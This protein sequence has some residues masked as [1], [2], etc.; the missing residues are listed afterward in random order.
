MTTFSQTYAY[1][2]QYLSLR[3]LSRVFSKLKSNKSSLLKGRITCSSQ[4]IVDLINER[5][6]N[7][8][9]SS[10]DRS[11]DEML[12]KKDVSVEQAKDMKYK[13]SIDFLNRLVT[14]V[15]VNQYKKKLDQFGK[16]FDIYMQRQ[17]SFIKI[18][19]NTPISPIF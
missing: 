16:E 4:S 11:N 5:C 3:Q 14:K 13:K 19:S 2:T 7:R 18:Y 6:A 10:P 17:G 1:E 12:G 15:F 9:H 8:G